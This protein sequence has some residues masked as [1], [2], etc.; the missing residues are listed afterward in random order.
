MSRAHIPKEI[1]ERVAV[2]AGHRCGY[3]LTSSLLV[4]SLFEIDHILPESLGGTAE[5]D[6]L[7]LACPLCNGH[8]SNR[9]ASLDPLTGEEVRLFDPRRQV[10][11]EHFA[12]ADAGDRIVG[13]TPAGRATVVALQL[14][15]PVLVHARR[16]WVAVGWHPPK[17]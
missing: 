7:W 10:W 14:N 13:L 16:A 15:R 4:G 17:D 8:K 9:I 6:N 1:R 3:C 12:W 11:S 2:Q 5:E